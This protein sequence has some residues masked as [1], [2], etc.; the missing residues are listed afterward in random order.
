M[1]NWP[2]STSRATRSTA[3]R[4]TRLIPLRKVAGSD[5]MSYLRTWWEASLRQRCSGLRCS[6]G[7]GAAA[8]GVAEQKALIL[9]RHS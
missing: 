8:A 6:A 4:T 9:P 1:H 5:C 7:A 2:P 3:I